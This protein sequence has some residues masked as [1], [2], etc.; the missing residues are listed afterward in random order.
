MKYL[1]ITLL[2]ATMNSFGQLVKVDY[3]DG[4]QKL[5][6]FFT[7]AQKANPKKAG[8]IILPA[9]MGVDAHAKESAEALAK[10]RLSCFCSDI[11][12]VGNNPKTQ[13]KLEKM[14]VSTKTI[15]RNIKKEFN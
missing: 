3:V 5:E 7:K 14:L 15:L 4:N 1:Y 9:W 11:Y 8:V 13:V 2:L 10:F 6:G 12:G